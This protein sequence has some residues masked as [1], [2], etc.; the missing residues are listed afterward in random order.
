MNRYLS[1]MIF[2]VNVMR[3]TLILFLEA[4]FVN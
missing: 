3:V 4:D 1:V 2:S